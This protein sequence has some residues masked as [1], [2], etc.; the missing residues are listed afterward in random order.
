MYL[1]LKGFNPGKNYIFLAVKNTLLLL[2]I[3]IPLDSLCW[4][5]HYV[6]T[7]YYLEKNHPELKKIFL[8]T[9]EKPEKI[10]DVNP[11]Y[12]PANPKIGERKP[13]SKDSDMNLFRFNREYC[14]DE[15]KFFT[16]GITISALEII[17][18]FS[19]EPDWGIDKNLGKGILSTFMGGSQ[20]FYHLY[21]PFP[22]FKVPLI[23]FP[24]GEA[25][26]RAQL[27]A[28]KSKNF[29][30]QG[31]LYEGYRN[32]ARAIHYIEDLLQPMH[33]DQTYWKFISIKS[34]VSGT[35]AITKNFHSALEKT[36]NYRLF[37]EISGIYPPYLITAFKPS[38]NEKFRTLSQMGRIKA[39]SSRKLVRK[40][41][42]TM[43]K[44]FPEKLRKPYKKRLDAE[45]IKEIFENDKFKDLIRIVKK[46]FDNLNL[47][48]LLKE[49]R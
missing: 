39:L 41:Y 2:I 9:P 13:C 17:S 11:Y 43:W 15:N 28:L 6:I 4:Q 29:F 24:Q 27:F 7:R 21:Y 5:N 30:S 44:I 3:L 16:P 26:Q 36:V 23:I 37:G 32:L 42:R 19:D 22:F 31:N 45:D 40:L 38:R 20:G 35:I 1:Q 46:S 34:P 14:P 12:N 33:T 25:P 8:K 48:P 49:V 10:K 47:E 18:F